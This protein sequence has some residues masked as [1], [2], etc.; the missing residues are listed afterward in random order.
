MWFTCDAILALVAN[1]NGCFLHQ[2]LCGWSGYATR[3]VLRGIM[4]LLNASFEPWLQCVV[5]GRWLSVCLREKGR[6]PGYPV[7]PLGF[8]F[9]YP[10]HWKMAC[11]CSENST[12]Q[13]FSVALLFLWLQGALS[14]NLLDAWMRH[15][16]QLKSTIIFNRSWTRIWKDQVLLK[17]VIIHSGWNPAASSLS[18]P[19]AG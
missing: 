4:S 11:V 13:L 16:E 3:I 15:W 7:W 12:N 5:V 10:S 18:P 14:C 8:L 17:W 9:L 1:D 2:V 19:S 6:L